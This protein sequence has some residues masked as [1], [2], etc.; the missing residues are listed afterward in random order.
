MS[1]EDALLKLNDAAM[2][3]DQSAAAQARLGK[4]VIV[5][6][7]AWLEDEAKRGSTPRHVH[8]AAAAGACCLYF[9]IAGSLIRDETKLAL[10][11]VRERN[12]VV[13]LFDDCLASFIATAAAKTKRTED[14]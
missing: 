2:G 1:V 14:K 12:K 6:I 3:G 13:A 7:D 10:A 4:R 11:L 5:M 9:S 8:D